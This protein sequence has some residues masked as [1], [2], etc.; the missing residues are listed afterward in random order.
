[1]MKPAAADARVEALVD[2]GLAVGPGHIDEGHQLLRQPVGNRHEAGR[3][4]V[5]RQHR[6]LSP[7]GLRLHAEDVIADAPEDIEPPDPGIIRGQEE[8][9]VAPARTEIG[10]LLDDPRDGS[11]FVVGGIGV[12]GVGAGPAEIIDAAIEP[13]LRPELL[14]IGDLG[15]EFGAVGLGVGFS[16][17]E[18]VIGIGQRFQEIGIDEGVDEDLPVLADVFLF[19]VELDE[20]LVLFGIP[21]RLGPGR[22]ARLA[23]VAAAGGQDPDIDLALVR[24][25]DGLGQKASLRELGL[26]NIGPVGDPVQAGV[27]VLEGERE[28]PW[29]GRPLEAQAEVLLPVDGTVAGQEAAMEPGLEAGL[30]GQDVDDAADGVGAVEDRRGA[31]EDLDP[32]DVLGADERGVGPGPA[33]ALETGPVDEIQNPAAGQ[34][35]HGRHEREAGR[36]EGPDPRDV[37]KAV[38]DVRDPLLRERLAGDDRAGRGDLDRG[39]GVAEGRDHDLLVLL[40]ERNEDEDERPAESLGPT[41]NSRS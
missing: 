25:P 14:R 24:P 27:V 11:G 37:L 29:S 9:E 12:V 19:P 31:P 3:L 26:E 7:V 30:P 16:G 8:T 10:I 41:W 36:A 34:A 18:A 33:V 6:R 32:V 15:P 28:G 39:L 4:A 35:A 21:G 22:G 17:Q 40:D 23:D 1:M 2:A 20:I 13:E 38:V 5:F